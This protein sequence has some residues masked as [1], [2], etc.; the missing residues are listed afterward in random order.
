MAKYDKTRAWKEARE[1]IREHRGSLTV[2]LVLMVINRLSG[3]VLPYTSK[4]LIDDIIGKH[5]SDLLMPLAA[6]VAGAT[7]IQAATSF[8]LSQVVSVAAQRLS[9]RFDLCG[10]LQQ[11]IEVECGCTELHLAIG[12]VGNEMHSADIRPP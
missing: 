6:A 10:I 5:R 11:R 1:L 12:S 8:A 4:F 9:P 7:V 3:L 2:G